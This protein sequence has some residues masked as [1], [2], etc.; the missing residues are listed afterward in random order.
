MGKNSLNILIC[1]KRKKIPGPM[2]DEPKF[3]SLPN[4][5]Y[6]WLWKIFK[7]SREPPPSGAWYHNYCAEFWENQLVG[8]EFSHQQRQGIEDSDL[9]LQLRAENNLFPTATI[10]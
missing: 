5:H 1:Q 8:N 4:Q 7:M 2:L 10:I 3:S 6:C 9:T